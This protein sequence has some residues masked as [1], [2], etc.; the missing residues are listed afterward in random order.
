ME[1]TLTITPYT[2]ASFKLSGE[3][4]RN[5]A[6]ELKDLN[7]RYNPNLR[8]GAGWIFSNKQFDKVSAFVDQVNNGEITPPELT[9]N[10]RKTSPPVRS[11]ASPRSSVTSITSPTNG[12]KTITKDGIEYQTITYTLVKPKTGMTVNVKLG[13]QLHKSTVLNTYEH[14]GVIDEVDITPIQ[15]LMTLVICNGQWSLKGYD[16]VQQVSFLTNATP[17]SD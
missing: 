15:D 1:Q 13:S 5:F 17:A 11:A 8:G 6:N 14:Y 16:G 9:N 2:D 12:V 3:L 7:G 4:T 10:Y